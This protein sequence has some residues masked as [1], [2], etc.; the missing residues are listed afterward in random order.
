MKKAIFFSSLVLCY[1]L[2]MESCAKYTVTT[3]QKNPADVVYKKTIAK[4][5]LWGIITKPQTVMDTTCGTGGLSEVKIT[6]N[7]G[8]SI[9]HV[10]TLGIVHLVRIEYKCQKEAPVIGH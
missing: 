6:S 2:P 3:S 8:H 10:A 9:I 7:I 1:W 5:Y 4:S